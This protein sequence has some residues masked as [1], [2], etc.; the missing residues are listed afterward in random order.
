MVFF[1]ITADGIALTLTIVKDVDVPWWVWVIPPGPAMVFAQFMAFHEMRVKKDNV[2]RNLDAIL[3]TPLID[4]AGLSLKPLVNR[5]DKG[6]ADFDVSLLFEN[7]GSSRVRYQIESLEVSLG[8]KTS[9]NK[10]FNNRGSV[11]LPSRQAQFFYPTIKDVGIVDSPINGRIE[12]VIRYETIPNIQIFRQRRAVDLVIF[13]PEG[14]PRSGSW[15][16]RWT[17]VE[18]P[19][20]EK[21]DSTN[22]GNP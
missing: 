7:I 14:D 20:D 18:S 15:Y 16:I 8:G 19:D 5:T 22:Y 4:F 13:P 11:I 17:F 10:R 1:F 6:L 21:I 3:E 2:S 9:E 12:Y